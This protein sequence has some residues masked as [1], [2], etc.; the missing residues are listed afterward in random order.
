MLQSYKSH[1]KF[2]NLFPFFFYLNGYYRSTVFEY[3]KFR[4][5]NI[6]IILFSISLLHN[7][8]NSC[9]TNTQLVFLYYLKLF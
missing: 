3:L 6:V 1:L 9:H 4:E 8:P 7:W 2:L 5:S